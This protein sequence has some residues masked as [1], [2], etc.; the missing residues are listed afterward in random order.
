MSTTELAELIDS[1]FR[2]L[3]EG[4]IVTGTIQ[5]IRPQVVLVDIGYKSE[6][7]ISISEFEDEEIE[8]GDQIEVLLERLENDEGIVVLSKEKAAHKQNWDKIVGVYRDGGLVKGKVKSVVKGGLMVNVGVEAFLPG[9]QVD[10]IPPRDLNEYVGKVYEFKIVKV[11]DDR[12]NIVLSRREVIE[13]ERADQRQRFLETVKEGD[14]VE[15]LVKN[16]TDFGAFVDL[17]GMDGLLHITDMSWG[18]VNHP[19]EML[20]IGQSLEVVILEVDRDKERVSLGLKQMT[21]NPWAD[22]ER[23]YPINSQVKGRVTKLLPYGAFVELEKGVEGLVH[24]SELSWVKRITRPSDVLKLDQ[25]IEA[26]VLSISVKEQKISLGVRQLE[27]NPWADIES[28]FPIGTVIKGQVR[29]LTPYGAFVG[30]EEGI[31]GMIHVSDMSWTRKINHPSEVL[32][33]GDEVEAIVLEIKKEDQRVSLG[34]K[35]LESDPWES[36]NDRFKVGDMVSGQ[37]AK[38]ASFGAFVNL[39][40]DIDGL[41][42]ISQLSEDHVERVKDVIKVGDEITARVIKVDSIERRIGLS[43]KA[44]NYDTEQLRR[45][46]ASFEALRPSSDMVGLEHAFNLA[47]RENEEWSPSEEK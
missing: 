41:I 13:A 25:E 17:R 5:E 32:K 21:D 34:I 45:E 36:I 7:A 12:K 23:K 24:V 4:S 2:E 10:I 22:I 38:I 27:D 14:K 44:V 33:K 3:R 29:N 46:T 8:V 28:R 31:D 6:G 40:G 39:D 47:T 43:I 9:S 35:Q 20:H 11:N 15:G 42:H 16:I 37:V 18:R 26:V 19:S 30:L 1:K